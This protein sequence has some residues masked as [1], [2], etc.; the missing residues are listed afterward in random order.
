MSEVTDAPAKVETNATARPL[1]GSHVWYELMTPDPDGA[2]AFYD[3][4]VGWTIG[5][6]IPGDQDYRM[7]GRSDGGFA[8]GVL[9]LTDEMR[10][11]GA[12]PIWLGYIGVDDVD[13]TVAQDRGQGWQ[14]ADARV[15][16]PAGPHRDGR[17][18]AGQSLLRDEADPAG[19]PSEGR[20]RRLL[21]RRSSSGSAG[22]SCRHPIRPP[23]ALF[24]PTC[25]AGA[26]TSS[27]RWASSANIGSLPM[28][29]RGSARCAGSC[30]AAAAAGA[31]TSACRRSKAV[32]AVKAGGG[33]VSMG[34]H[35]VPAG[36]HI[37]IG[38]DPQGAEFAL[39]GGQVTRRREKMAAT[40]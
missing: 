32:E 19:R 8:G 29:A 39:V 1:Q 31:I 36:D 18:P 21:A 25:S 13:A 24:T 16:H 2:K 10:Q 40:R 28:T 38:N 27:C 12:R 30:R 11:H 33:E 34:P 20:E 5:E 17:R 26:A 37:I 3:A 22:T 23:P 6:R 7:I 35:Q 14:D 15:R 4:V 9:A